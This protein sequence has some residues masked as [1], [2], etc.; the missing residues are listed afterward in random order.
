MVFPLYDDNPF[1]LP[2]PPYVTWSLIGFNVVIFLIQVS[3][4]PEA[5][6]GI[7]ASFAATPAV[8]SGAEPA[9]SIPA[10]L[11]L[12]TSMFLHG[13][14]MHII[15]NMVYL[16]VFG[17]DIE[18]ALGHWRFLVFYLASG[19]LAALAYTAFNPSNPEPMVG[20]SGGSP[21]CS[22]PT[23]CCVPARRSRCSCFASSFACAPTG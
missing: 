19:V 10:P 9:G 18:E 21:A 16:W 15:G 23:C 3:S 22:P 8:L 20:A 1:K 11:T 17:D 12:L 13:G 2:V 4:S 5:A 7:L 14:W 6:A